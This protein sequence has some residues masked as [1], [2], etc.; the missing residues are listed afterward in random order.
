M[1]LN[2]KNIGWRIDIIWRDDS[3]TI[4]HKAGNKVF[5]TQDRGVSL[6]LGERLTISK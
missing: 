4:L 3:A 6:I 1:W 5:S 2:L